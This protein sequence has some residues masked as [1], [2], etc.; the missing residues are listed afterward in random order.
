MPQQWCLFI[1]VQGMALLGRNATA[2][3]PLPL[4][5]GSEKLAVGERAV[6]LSHCVCADVGVVVGPHPRLPQPGA[7]FPASVWFSI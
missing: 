5:G 3:F 7:L 6:R 4:K 2:L 1:S